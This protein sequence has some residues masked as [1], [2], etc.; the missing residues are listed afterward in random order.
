MHLLCS[1]RWKNVAAKR[2]KKYN[3]VNTFSE[4]PSYIIVE[5]T[6]FGNEVSCVDIAVNAKYISQKK[7]GQNTK[8]L[9]CCKQSQKHWERVYWT[10]GAYI[11]LREKT[12]AEEYSTKTA[13]FPSLRKKRR[14]DEGANFS[15]VLTLMMC[16]NNFLALSL[17]MQLRLMKSSV[18][19][20]EIFRRSYTIIRD[21]DG[22]YPHVSQRIRGSPFT[23]DVVSDLT[24]SEYQY[25]IFWEFYVGLET[26]AM[27]LQ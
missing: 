21:V 9:S 2:Q 5:L 12:T 24:C 14:Q 27:Y 8:G 15:I 16:T 23:D 7:V 26:L 20:S 22:L 3:V 6:F 13:F 25:I 11:A 17:V 4:Q 1:K 18:A 19:I 10:F